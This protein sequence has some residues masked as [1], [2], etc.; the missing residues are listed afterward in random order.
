MVS[1]NSYLILSMLNLHI[2][3]KLRPSHLHSGW[4]WP[5]ERARIATPAIGDLSLADSQPH[6]FAFAVFRLLEW[7]A[8]PLSPRAAHCVCLSD[9][10]SLVW[11]KAALRGNTWATCMRS[12]LSLLDINS[13]CFYWVVLM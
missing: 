1:N 9:V 10:R 3:A 6:L 2:A 4:F 7:G 11:E 12:H 5:L 8:R 13:S